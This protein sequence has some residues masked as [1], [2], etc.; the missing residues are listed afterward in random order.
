MAK[1]NVGDTV[2]ILKKNLYG[3]IFGEN[4]VKNVVKV[5]NNGWSDLYHLECPPHDLLVF[6]D[7]ELTLVKRGPVDRSKDDAYSRA[8]ALKPDGTVQDQI[9]L[10][11]WLM[12]N[13]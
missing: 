6:F 3:D 8:T 2:Q 4:T 1:F 9:T 12:K 5:T 13:D 11:E 7:T 10:A